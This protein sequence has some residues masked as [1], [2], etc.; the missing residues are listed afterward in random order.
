[1]L[2]NHSVRQLG[3]AA[4]VVATSSL[5]APVAKASLV[6]TVERQSDH[7]ALVSVSGQ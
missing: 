4:L 6:F 7:T 5:L 1:M 3:I 2:S